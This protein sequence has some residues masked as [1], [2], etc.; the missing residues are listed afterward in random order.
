[1]EITCNKQLLPLIQM[2]NN[3]QQFLFGYLT[4]VDFLYFDKSFYGT[5]FFNS[6]ELPIFANAKKYLDF[7]KQT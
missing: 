1:M 3:T 4:I 7:F 6:N 2:Y 5:N